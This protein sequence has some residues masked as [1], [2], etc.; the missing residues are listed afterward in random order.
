MEINVRETRR[1]N[2]EWTI[3]SHLQYW[4]LEKQTKKLNTTQKTKKIINTCESHVFS[5]GQ[6]YWWRKPLTCRKSLT[7]FIT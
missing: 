5:A 7:K 4:A 3:Q 2:Q 6:F 1:G